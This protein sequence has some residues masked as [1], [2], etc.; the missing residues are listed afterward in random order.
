[1]DHNSIEENRSSV[2]SGFPFNRLVAWGLFFWMHL[3]FRWPILAF[4]GADLC[5]C[6]LYLRHKGC[7]HMNTLAWEKSVQ[8]LYSETSTPV[9]RSPAGMDF[10]EV[11]LKEG[12]ASRSKIWALRALTLQSGGT[13]A[14][15]T[16]VL[17]ERAS[18]Q[19][20]DSS[21]RSLS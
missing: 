8:D 20:E 9:A 10:G 1:M 6:A 4:D 15:Q 2:R 3:N 19:H 16:T 13:D 12:S 21:N 5:G 7:L 11:P 14:A 17:V 18:N